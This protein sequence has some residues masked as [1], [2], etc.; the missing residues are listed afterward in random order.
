[1]LP[2]IIHITKMSALLFYL[3]FRFTSTTANGAKT[4]PEYLQ[5]MTCGDCE[6]QDHCQIETSGYFCPDQF[7]RIEIQYNQDG[8]ISKGL[9]HLTKCV[10]PHY[11]FYNKKEISQ[12]CCFWTPKMGC[13]QLLNKG[14]SKKPHCSACTS[15]GEDGCPCGPSCGGGKLCNCNSFIIV[16]M[17]TILSDYIYI[18]K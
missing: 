8:N 9:E 18:I 2:Y 7:D 15:Y 17:C 12:M 16:L 13:Q 11:Y 10:A 6:S 14:Y 1:M 3:I 4:T 5:K